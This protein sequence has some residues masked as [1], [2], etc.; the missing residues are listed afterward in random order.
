MPPVATPVA[1][2]ALSWDAALEDTLPSGED[3]ASL[4]SVLTRV[5]PVPQAASAPLHRVH[6]VHRRAVNLHI[7]DELVALV[8]PELDDA[9]AT[10]RVPVHDWTTLP[11]QPGDEVWIG[12]DGLR[13]ETALGPI[14]VLTAPAHP[15]RPDDVCLCSLSPAQLR[16]A[17]E[18][19]GRTPAPSAL[20]AF[21]RIAA[22]LLA[23]HADA[24]ETALRHGDPS[25]ITQAAI[26][27]LGLGEG[28]TPSGD[29]VLTGV[30]FLSAQRGMRLHA[31]R[32][33]LA[34]AVDR[35]GAARTT[36]LSTATIRHALRA[37]APQR[38][39]ALVQALRDDDAVRLGS[40][41]AHVAAIG[42]TSGSDMLTG[43]RLALRTEAALRTAPLPATP[44]SGNVPKEHV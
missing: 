37:R 14:A 9:P 27:L 39:H 32:A 17:D 22:P 23:E 30:A 20:T 38:L 26:P 8:S 6:S 3:G 41:A 28:L 29:D 31:A 43:V 24:L 44:A 21:G 19:I 2:R 33:S 1:V 16:R 25:G 18:I 42:H 7:A 36:P 34:A 12:S 11:V 35:A 15:W 40:A 10:V 5:R 13:I 4:R